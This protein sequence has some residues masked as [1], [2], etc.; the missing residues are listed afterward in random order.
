MKQANNFWIRSQWPRGLRPVACWNCGYEFRWKRGCL[1]FV[2][3]VCCQVEASASTWSLVQRISTECGVTECDRETSKMKRLW[4]TRGFR[5]TNR[6]IPRGAGPLGERTD[7]L[8]VTDRLCRY[9]QC[10]HSLKTQ[11]NL[12]YCNELKS[13]RHGQAKGVSKGGEL[14]EVVV[15]VL[16]SVSPYLHTEGVTGLVKRRRYT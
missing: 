13:V 16:Q 9:L 3:V 11:M 8:Q 4:P 5:A 6:P 2:S 10:F 15:E 12:H 1:S 7:W 14:R